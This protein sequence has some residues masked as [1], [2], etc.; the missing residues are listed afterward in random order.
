M[1]IVDDGVRAAALLT[2]RAH[3]CIGEGQDLAGE[4]D[5][6][7]LAHIDG[8]VVAYGLVG[9][10]HGA[11][12]QVDVLVEGHDERGRRQG[13]IEEAIDDMQ[14][15]TRLHG[16]RQ[17]VETAGGILKRCASGIACLRRNH[18]VLQMCL[19]AEQGVGRVGRTLCIGLPLVVG[20]GLRPGDG[21]AADDVLDGEL[22]KI[23]VVPAGNIAYVVDVELH[24]GERMAE[25]GMHA[26]AVSGRRGIIDRL[27]HAE[28]EL[29]GDIDGLGRIAHGGETRGG[30]EGLDAGKLGP[31]GGVHEEVEGAPGRP[32][33]GRGGAPQGALVLGGTV[34]GDEVEVVAVGRQRGAVG[35]M[36]ERRD[37]E[38]LERLGT[39]G[40]RVEGT[41]LGLGGH[42]ADGRGEG[43]GG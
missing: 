9:R 6:G 1:L 30:V 32:V 28:V 20:L 31:V 3:L 34:G 27:G 29:V 8:D 36:P 42:D 15:G 38:G 19:A 13:A 43:E 14:A 26:A 22:L 24:I 5:F 2:A 12:G 35:R 40:Q 21:L 33:G 23:D 39:V 7:R 4:L 41:R 16:L 11:G 10:P 17:Q 37:T 25:G 18:L